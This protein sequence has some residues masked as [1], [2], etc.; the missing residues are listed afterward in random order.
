M[1]HSDLHH[2]RPE[3]ASLAANAFAALA[4]ARSALSTATNRD[5]RVGDV[6]VPLVVCERFMLAQVMGKEGGRTEGDGLHS[7]R[8]GAPAV[9]V[10]PVGCASCFRGCC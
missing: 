9:P 5:H 3:G 2:L 6:V 4:P 1:A 8:R 10:V 7:R